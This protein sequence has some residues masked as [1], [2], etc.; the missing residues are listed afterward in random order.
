MCIRDRSILTLSLPRF[1]MEFCEVT[2][3]TF[4][5]MDEIL[6]CDHSNES[7]LPILSHDAICFSE[8]G[9]NLPLATFGSER[10]KRASTGS[11]ITITRPY[12]LWGL[13]NYPWMTK[14]QL[15]VTKNKLLKTVR[16]TSFQKPQ[17]KSV[18][19]SS[20]FSIR[21]SLNFV[22]AELFVPSCNFWAIVFMFHSIWWQFPLFEFW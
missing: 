20:T 10:V 1:L 16:L 19:I 5:T 7:S 11:Q 9:R 6:W 14:L 3:L 13:R 18:S 15:R 8:F 2:R 12:S 22:F 21:S 4:E 17:L